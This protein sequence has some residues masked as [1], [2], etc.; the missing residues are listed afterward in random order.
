MDNTHVLK[1]IKHCW[2]K[3]KENEEIF[4]V[5]ESEDS[6]LL[7]QSSDLSDSIKF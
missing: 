4:Y 2:K 1:P 6:I 7:C 5:Y 3:C